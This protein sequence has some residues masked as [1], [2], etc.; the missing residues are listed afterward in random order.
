MRKTLLLIGGNSGIGLALA[1]LLRAQGDTVITTARASDVVSP[2]HRRFDALAPD[3]SELPP[4][5][6]GL[7]YFPGT[8]LPTGQVLRPDGGLSSI[9]TF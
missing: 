8:V 2:N 1:G 7:V 5:I 4:V 3:L 9:R 6:D